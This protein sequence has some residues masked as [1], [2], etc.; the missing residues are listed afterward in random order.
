V[1]NGKVRYCVFVRMDGFYAGF[2]KEVKKIRNKCWMLAIAT[3]GEDVIKE[4]TS[5]VFC[6]IVSA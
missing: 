6:V 3:G 5:R 2:N 4:S 1:I